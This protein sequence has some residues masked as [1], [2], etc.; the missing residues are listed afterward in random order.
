ML[1]IS[2]T[3]FC[4]PQKYNDKINISLVAGLAFA[5]SPL[6]I[7]WSKTA[8]SD[9]LLC[10]TIGACLLLFWRRMASEE[11]KLCISPWIFLG[12]A[13]LTKGPVAIVIVST[14]LV[15]FLITQKNW[16]NLLS[17]INFLK[18]ILITFLISAPWYLIEFYKEGKVFFDNFFGYHNFQRYTSVVNNHSEPFWFY[19][20]IMIIGSLPFSAFLFHGIYESFK[21]LFSSFKD[22]SEPSESLFIYSLCWL[23]TVFIFFTISATKLPSY[24]LPATPAAAILISNSFSRLNYGKQR[25]SY[26]WLF[27]IL[28]FF[29][30]SISFYLS[31]NWLKLINDP[32]MPNLAYDIISSGLILKARLVFS[33]LT[34]I[35][36]II[37]FMKPIKSI[38]YLQVF[39]LISQLIIMTPIRKLADSTRQLPLRNVSKQ[40]LNIRKV[41]EPLAMIGIRKPSLHFYSKQIVFYESSSKEGLVNLSER[42]LFD[43]RRTN[44]DKPNYDFN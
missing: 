18:G 41:G 12:M 16:K 22:E 5:L 13:I 6:V 40:I 20:F 23:L 36:I 38:I 35:S 27:T 10:G 31:N 26:L 8:V 29:G 9:S 1:L 33:I 15:S 4:W 32:E 11:N 43:K 19:F 34:V 17:K 37:F 44:S 21:D 39:F 7:V 24:W 30:L 42:L 3:L 14:T 2:D 25:I 28:I